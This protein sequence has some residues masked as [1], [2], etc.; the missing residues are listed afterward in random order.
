[1]LPVSLG[2]HLDWKPHGVM[3]GNCATPLASLGSIPHTFRYVVKICTKFHGCE[4]I[5]SME[6][7]WRSTFTVQD[8]QLMIS[9]P[10][11]FELLVESLEQVGG[12]LKS[13]G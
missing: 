12:R 2:G 1:M 5:Y 3:S 4:S 9:A 10:H 7:S 8:L 6:R 13:E 11:P